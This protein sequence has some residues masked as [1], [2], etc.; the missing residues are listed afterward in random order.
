MSMMNLNGMAC[1][2]GLVMFT[3]NTLAKIALWEHVIITLALTHVLAMARNA[4]P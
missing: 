4:A 2:V 3:A 1:M